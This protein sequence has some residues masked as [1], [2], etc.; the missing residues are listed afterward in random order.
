MNKKQLGGTDL[1]V[2]AV[3][4]GTA[5]FGEK[6]SQQQA[7]ELMDAFVAGGG[8]FLDTANVYC[9][10]VPGLD[11]ISEQFIGRW[12]KERGTQKEV[13]VATKGGHYAFA[14]PEVSRVNPKGVGEDLEES[15]CTLGLET[16]DLYWLHRDDTSV[17]VGVIIDMME[18]FVKQGKVRWYGASNYSLQRLQQAAD[19][20]AK[21]GVTGFSAVSNQWSLAAGNPGANP[22]PDPS[23]IIMDEPMYRWH[24]A[25]N[26]PMVPYSSTAQGF[27]A[28]L[29]KAGAQARDG[30]LES[31]LPAGAMDE[32]LA[33]AFINPRNLRIYEALLACRKQTGASMQALSLAALGAAPFPVVPAAAARNA[34]QLAEV[35]EGGGIT[36]LPDWFAAYGV[37]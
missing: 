17:P 19:Y 5:N 4:L 22:N 9:R 13:H 7:F 18:D 11:N 6:L 14:A 16:I 10:W 35:L 12:M 21:K 33:K 8:N 15:L 23:L 32:G 36:G 29:E 26:T 37:E 3:C 2:S 27:F 28:K 31:P 25:S 24:V 1:M 34:A 20:A 30:R